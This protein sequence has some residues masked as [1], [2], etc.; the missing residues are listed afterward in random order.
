MNLLHHITIVTVKSEI[1]CSP[2]N[3]HTHPNKKVI[4]FVYDQRE[5]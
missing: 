4:R 2:D 3:T 5:N 1:D